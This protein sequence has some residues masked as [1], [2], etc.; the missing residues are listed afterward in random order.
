MDPT[1]KYKPQPTETEQQAEKAI[2]Q[3]MDLRRQGY[4]VR[5]DNWFFLLEALPASEARL[6]AA[7]CQ[8]MPPDKMAD[9]FSCRPSD[10]RGKVKNLRVRIEAARHKL[11]LVAGWSPQWRSVALGYVALIERR[12]LEAFPVPF[13]DMPAK[14]P[15]RAAHNAVA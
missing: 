15:A 6:V 2:L 13:I 14:A 5:V 10:P 3:Q 11:V 7:F 12:L 1:P 8:G 4:N 9:A